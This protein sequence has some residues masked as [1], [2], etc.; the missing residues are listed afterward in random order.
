MLCHQN[1]KNSPI[2]ILIWF[3]VKRS[4]LKAA[5]QGLADAVDVF[6]ESIGFQSRTNRTCTC[7]SQRTW[8]AIKVGHT[9]QLNNMGSSALAAKYGALSVDQRWIP[10]ETGVKALAESGTVA[11]LLPGAFYFL[12]ETQQ[13]PVA[14][15]EHKTPNGDRDRLK[16]RHVSLLLI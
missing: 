9:E 11:T 4:S 16:P 7:S 15:R 14:L 1:T 10:D 6:C 12:K 5:E 8:V 2:V 13:P 3:A